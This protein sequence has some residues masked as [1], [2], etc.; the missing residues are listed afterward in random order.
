[1]MHLFSRCSLILFSGK[2]LLLSAFFLLTR[3]FLSKCFFISDRIC[4]DYIARNVKDNEVLRNQLP[5]LPT[6]L[7]TAV[8]RRVSFY[9]PTKKQK[10]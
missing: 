10:Y 6:K 8:K 9:R 3:V 5:C 2:H 1:M 7:Q 4:E